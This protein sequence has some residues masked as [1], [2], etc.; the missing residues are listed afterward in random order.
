LH[1]LVVLIIFFFD[2]QTKAVAAA[3]GNKEFDK[4]MGLRDEEFKA[5][6]QVFLSTAVASQTVPKVG[7]GKV[8][9]SSSPLRV[10]F[11]AYSTPTPYFF[12][13]KKIAN[14]RSAASVILGNSDFRD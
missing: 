10:P 4:A 9:F 13:C 3:V 11:L 12:F 2:V 14:S 5:L 1:G 8:S 6:H 7:E